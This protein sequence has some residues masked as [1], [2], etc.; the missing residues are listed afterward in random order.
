M[1]YT[2]N[3]NKENFNIYLQ[4]FRERYNNSLKCLKKYIMEYFLY[5]KNNKIIMTHLN[6]KNN[7]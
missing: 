2:E 5:L 1:N 4:M 6:N 3:K 7:K